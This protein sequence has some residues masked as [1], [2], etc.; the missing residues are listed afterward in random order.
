[1]KH[2]LGNVFDKVVLPQMEGEERAQYLADLKHQGGAKAGNVQKFFE[3]LEKQKERAGA[4]EGHE[5]DAAMKGRAVGEKEKVKG[6]EKAVAEQRQD[7]KA[8]DAV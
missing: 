6:E 7:A 2:L 3:H 4:A 8:H 5:K 1:M